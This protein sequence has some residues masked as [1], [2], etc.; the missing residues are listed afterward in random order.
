MCAVKKA[1][2]PNMKKIASLK[3]NSRS[4]SPIHEK[5]NATTRM[6]LFLKFVE[7]KAET[8]KGSSSNGFR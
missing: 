8:I 7:M 3:T 1:T 6:I 5:T 2:R 4:V